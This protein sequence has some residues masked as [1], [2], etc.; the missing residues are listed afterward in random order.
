MANGNIRQASV[1]A[2]LLATGIGL[3]AS[4]MP[5]VRCAETPTRFVQP[6]ADDKT[7]QK[8]VAP[9][10][11][12]LDRYGDPL[13]SGAVARLG[14]V[15]FRA[16]DE[17]DGLAF[18]PDG[19]T[20][21]VS[22]RGGVFLF[23]ADG[24]K[25]IK[26]LAD[27][28]SIGRQQNTLAFSPDGK[29]LASW[30]QTFVSDEK[31][32]RRT[33]EVVRVSE[34]AGDG[35]PQDHDIAHVIWFGWASDREPLVVCLEKG[36]V[37]L[38]HLAQP[39]SARRFECEGLRRPELSDYV[40]CA[41]APAGHTLAVVGEQYII[42]V[43]D[44][45]T[46]AE[47]C[48]IPPDK[49][50]NL[51]ALAMSPDGRFL[52]TLQQGQASPYPQ[53]VYHW[54]AMTGRK[55]RTMA[56]DHKNMT[57]LA[58]APDGKTLAAAGW[59]GIRCYDAAT[60]RERSRG[61][62]DGSNTN[63]IA[64]SGDGQTL[65]TLQRHSGAFHLWD[66]ATGKRKAN[67]VGHTARPHGTSFSPDGRR[68]ASG[69]GVDGTIHMWDLATS[70]SLFSIHKSR[71]VRDAAL[72]R[73]GCW[74][75]STWTDDELWISDAATGARQDVIKLE[76]PERPDTQ[77]SA[78]SM[79]LS[80]D[81][82]TLVAFSYYYPKKAGVGADYNETLLTGWDPSIRKQ[83]FRRRLPNRS[84]WSAVSADARL[85]ATAYPSSNS[86]YEQKAPGQG[87]MRLEDLAT[88]ELS[89]SFPTLEGQ[90]W[91]LAFSPDGRL[92]ASVNS[93]FKRRKKDDPA[94]TGANLLLWELATAAEVLSL[95]MTGQHRVAFSP[96]GRLL[97]FTAPGREIPV[98]D[99]AQHRVVRRFKGF[100]AEVT[101]LAFAPEG[102]RLVSGLA[103]STLLIWE[104]GAPEAPPTTKLGAEALAKAWDDL[105]GSDAPRAF[106]ARWELANEPKATLTLFQKHLKSAPPSDARRLQKLIDDLDSQL[107]PVRT[108]ANRELEELGDLAAG[109]LRQ[110]T[111]KS[112]SLELRRR[113]Q[114]LLEKLRGPVTR[115]E[116]LRA[117][118]SATVL[119]DI[120]TPEA[121]KLL[122]SLAKGAPEA[123]L[124][125]EAQAALQR[126]ELRGLRP[127]GQ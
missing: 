3:A 101:W 6:T 126:L 125:Q 69:G 13:P 41:H 100:D 120:A 39:D 2:G 63:M 53:S 90:T 55:L 7:E 12:Q 15:R 81:G 113:A 116:V 124:T 121:Q 110:V 115:P 80:A 26:H 77:Q 34:W 52:A 38:R 107:F 112:S 51:R 33:K 103:D 108:A 60:G 21:A 123:R 66:V 71:W 22:S 98:W 64:F 127:R 37:S 35:K 32:V 68:M 72:S 16:R 42:H 96:D 46:G 48:K 44:T 50:E 54:D 105:A 87:P 89:L 78:I 67:P 99:L 104:V 102:R 28:A 117:M 118:R 8:L 106:R 57:T 31:G 83:L 75:Y 18:A 5:T 111:T 91:P 59:N 85:L 25:R 23:A 56:T 94:S 86:E 70:K 93:N 109:A 92:L 30:G 114:A 61:E 43:W 24:G 58:F 122:E 40:L 84:S 4:Q 49:D 65:A 79:D 17:A 74:I 97:A 45:R 9:G 20:V 29:R 88:G 76:D 27:Y 62:G 10:Q 73:D 82:K 19:K 119:E 14:T 1:I 11:V 47:R 95:P 36:A